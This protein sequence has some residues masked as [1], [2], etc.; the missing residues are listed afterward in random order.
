MLFLLLLVDGGW[1]ENDTFSD[2]NV[3]CGNGSKEKILSCNN[4][5]PEYGGQNCSCAE[6]T[7]WTTCNE[8]IATFREE[9]QLD[10]CPG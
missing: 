5:K 3:S 10:P 2:C 8:S 1:S 7:N 9:C 6:I 4:P